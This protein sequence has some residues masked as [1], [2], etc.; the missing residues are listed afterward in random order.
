MEQIH[1]RF[2]TEQVKVLF[3]GYMEGNLERGGETPPRHP[4]PLFDDNRR[5]VPG[6][7]GPGTNL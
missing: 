4:T 5:M 6:L 7:R 1:K 2:T 3:K